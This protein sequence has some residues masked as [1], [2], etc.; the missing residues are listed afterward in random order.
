MTPAK[1]NP[2]SRTRTR[3]P[4][5]EPAAR[6]QPTRVATSAAQPARPAFGRARI[7]ILAQIAS[8][9]P[10]VLVAAGAALAASGALS[11][12]GVALGVVVAACGVALLLGDLHY[13]ST[14]RLIAGLHA[15][16]ADPTAE[17]RLVNLTESLC[18]GFGLPAPSVVVV[19]DSAPNALAL[20]RSAQSA[21]LVVTTG[22][23]ATLDRMQLEAILAHELA[24]VKRGD[25]A[26]AAV[27][28]RAFGLVAA[29]SAFGSRLA[30]HSVSRDREAR[31]DLA[32]TS[33]TRYPPA[34][35]DALEALASA[36]TVRPKALPPAV[37]RLTAW[38]WC[39]PF[40]LRSSTRSRPGELDLALRIAAL[41][42]L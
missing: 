12:V 40:A 39:A 9:A 22:A 23:L 28:T 2:K 25:T 34:L 6:R 5:P 29:H 35:A 20:G 11:V 32:A 30:E 10:F 15:R 17:A 36:E 7:G 31:A 38:Q 13:A 26:A 42:E 14:A 41:R 27:V 37:A 4:A 24:H 16:P 21:T 18:F 1:V 19:E 8:A 3:Q 33:V